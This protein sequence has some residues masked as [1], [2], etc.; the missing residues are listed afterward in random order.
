METY[1]AQESAPGANA[2]TSIELCAGA[3]GQALGLE[4]AG[5]R[6]VALVEL[7]K[8]A[9]A[10]LR[11]NRPRWDVYEQDV[12]KFDATRFQNVDLVAAGVPCPPFSVAGKQLGELDDRDLFPTA[13]RIVA[14]THPRA[15]MIENVR[16]I[17]DPLFADYR[18]RTL[19]TLRSLGYT[20]E[21]KLL[22]AR[23]FGVPQLRPRAI[24][25]ALRTDLWPGFCWP[26]A[27]DEAPPTVGEVLLP[28]MKSNGWRGA[29]KWALQANAIAPTLGGGISQ[30]WRA[31]SRPNP[32]PPCLGEPR[33]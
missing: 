14:E 33:G 24:L 19:E 29:K 32:S 18:A 25:V 1:G 12:T 13:L 23:D 21:W 11:L 3:G 7:D 4:M 5:F 20:G 27:L 31:R 6:H 22:N 16:G 30:A 9:C 28:A 10:T 17:L 2:L 8:W 26:K 15:V